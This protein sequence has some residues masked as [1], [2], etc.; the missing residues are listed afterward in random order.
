METL[1]TLFV[2]AGIVG[3]FYFRKKDKKKRN[4]AAGLS[5]VSFVIFGI[6]FAEEDANE[7][8][9]E[10]DEIQ[11]VSQQKKDPDVQKAARKKSSVKTVDSE[12]KTEEE[13]YEESIFLQNGHP[14]FGGSMA[15]AEK[16]AKKFDKKSITLNRRDWTEDS[17]IHIPLAVDDQIRSI[18][19]YPESL[20]INDEKLFKIISAYLPEENMSENYEE[21]EFTEYLSE[22]DT[23][24]NA[25]KLILYSL[26]EG[27]ETNLGSLY[28]V[29]HVEN[30]NVNTIQF[31]SMRP[32]SVSTRGLSTLVEYDWEPEF[33]LLN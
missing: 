15:D 4:I 9:S 23:P 7:S 13:K 30:N 3:F 20:S 29:I 12:V 22:D 10:K 27:A 32:N 24:D 2:V 25:N 1:I 14:V 21:P 26:K 6:F 17:I 11:E 18:E 16:Y 8:Q 31:T 19:L 28:I 5:I 33:D